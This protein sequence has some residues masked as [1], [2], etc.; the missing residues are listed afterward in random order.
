MSNTVYE[1]YKEYKEKG[2]DDDF[3]NH[4]YE[5]MMQKEPGL[6]PFINDFR[7][8]PDGAENIA[9]YEMNNRIIRIDP[10]RLREHIGSEVIK[11]DPI[12]TL[13]VVRNQIEHAR[14]LQRLHE[15]RDDIESTV[16]RMALKDYALEHGLDHFDSYD[17]TDFFSL[18]ARWRRLENYK[19]NPEARIADVRAWRYLVNL[20]KNQRVSEDLLIAR[21]NLF[22]A[23]TQGYTENPYYIEAPTYRF[24][25]NMGMY[26]EY[27][28]LKKRVEEQRDY[29]FETRLMYGLPLKT[30]EFD[31]QILK[32]VRLQKRKKDN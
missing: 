3:I 13:R 32:K 6:T 4:A 16:I 14:N 24:L 12:F 5:L 30:D 27:Y 18:D 29:S 7:L 26:H 19:T 25:L 22:Y 10:E 8:E 15:G 1:L 17:K 11:N 23:Y 21:S 9:S 31:A 28:L 20:L 2:I